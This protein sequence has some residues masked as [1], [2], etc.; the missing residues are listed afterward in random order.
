MQSMRQLE[1]EK[2]TEMEEILSH[3][4]E[5]PDFLVNLFS[6]SVQEEMNVY[7]KS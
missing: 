1:K 5:E 3:G 2:M 7:S 4:I 6:N